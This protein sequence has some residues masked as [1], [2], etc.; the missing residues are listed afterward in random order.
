MNASRGNAMGQARRKRS[1]HAIAHPGAGLPIREL[2]PRRIVLPIDGPI[3]NALSILLAVALV[4]LAANG[5]LFIL[6]FLA[7]D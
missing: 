1:V 3:M 2:R 7:L 6:R 4:A 5:V